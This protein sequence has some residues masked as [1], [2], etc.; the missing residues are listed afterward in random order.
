MGI[1]KAVLVK[2]FV[3]SIETNNEFPLPSVKGKGL[4]EHSSAQK[5]H[6]GDIWW[7]MESKECT[8]VLRMESVHILYQ[9][10][11]LFMEKEG[12]FSPVALCDQ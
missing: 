5:L 4:G 7:E 6:H 2:I 10:V 12:D 1:G 3:I 11:C 8:D 9:V